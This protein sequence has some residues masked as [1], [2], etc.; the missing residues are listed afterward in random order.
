MQNTKEMFR[1]MVIEKYL[2]RNGLKDISSLRKITMEDLTL[3]ADS[4]YE[5][6]LSNDEKMMLEKE[7]SKIKVDIKLKK[8]LDR[9]S[10]SMTWDIRS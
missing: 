4:D 7:N 5:K 6:I 2:D 8:M 3:S 1:Q 10:F 9:T